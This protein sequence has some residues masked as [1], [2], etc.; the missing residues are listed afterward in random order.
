MTDSVVVTPHLGIRYVKTKTDGYD[1]TMNGKQAFK[2]GKADGDLWQLPLGVSV[3]ADLWEGAW[4]LAPYADI[5]VVRQFGDTDMTTSVSATSY[6]AS[7]SYR[8][9]VAGKTMGEVK[10]GISA[11]R[12]NHSF[13]LSYTGAVGTQ[14]TQTHALTAHYNYRF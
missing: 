13:G 4:K 7:D 9:D 6:A 11:E 8:F 14:G 12:K 5:S 10:L 2:A 3:K 1:I